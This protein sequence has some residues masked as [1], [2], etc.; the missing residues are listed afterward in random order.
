MAVFC[1]VWA[2]RH[3]R[4]KDN[5]LLDEG[6]IAVWEH[7]IPALHNNIHTNHNGW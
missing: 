7:S 6:L 3:T 1:F 4:D 2:T 5:S